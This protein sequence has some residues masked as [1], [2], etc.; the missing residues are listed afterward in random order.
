MLLLLGPCVFPAALQP[1]GGEGALLGCL[2]FMALRL[3]IVAAA[4]EVQPSSWVLNRAGVVL[5]IQ[6]ITSSQVGRTTLTMPVPRM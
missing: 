2:S 4:L 5:R 6:P 1:R 3:V